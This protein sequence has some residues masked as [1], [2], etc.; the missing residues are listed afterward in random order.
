VISG[1]KGTEGSGTADGVTCGAG[2]VAGDDGDAGPGVGSGDPPSAAD[3]SVGT[4]IPAA[5]A[6]A[7]SVNTSVFRRMVSS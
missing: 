5:M 1:T 7:A 3:A 6:V 4:A 2:T